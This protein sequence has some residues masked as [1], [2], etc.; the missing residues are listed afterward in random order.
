VV[1]LSITVLI[2]IMDAGV[3]NRGRILHPGG[4]R[5]TPDDEREEDEKNLQL[6]LLIDVVIVVIEVVIIFVVIVIVVVV[7]IAIE[8]LLVILVDVVV[9]G[10]NI[11]RIR[12]NTLL[13]IMPLCSLTLLNFLTV[14]SNLTE[15]LRIT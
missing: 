11:T 2:C 6:V 3:L 5:L 7:V 12:H 8:V 14:S 15:G 1:T 10:T 9:T 13:G 4:L